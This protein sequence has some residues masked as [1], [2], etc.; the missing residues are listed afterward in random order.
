MAKGSKRAKAQAGR[1]K[2][3]AAKFARYER[4]Q[5]GKPSEVT[6]YGRRWHAR[7]NGVPMQARKSQPWWAQIARVAAMGA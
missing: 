1:A 2:R 7:R 4:R 6:A 5:D 3:R